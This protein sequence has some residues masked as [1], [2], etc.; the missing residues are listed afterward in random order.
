MAEKITAASIFKFLKE[1]NLLSKIS[2]NGLNN[3]GEK[4]YDR[5]G[6]LLEINDLTCDDKGIWFSKKF[7]VFIAIY[8]Y[9]S[10][11]SDEIIY[12]RILDSNDIQIVKPEEVTE[13][14]W[15]EK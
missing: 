14:R 1:E 3:L 15:I 5:F 10:S 7:N 12:C 2:K 13:I 8:G 9:E 6:E 4:F 11:E